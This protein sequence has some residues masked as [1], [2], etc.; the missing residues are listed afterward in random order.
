MPRVFVLDQKENPLMPTPP[1][2]A[3]QLLKQGRAGVPRG[4]YAGTHEGTVLVRKSGYFDIRK[5]GVRI[6]QGINAKYFTLIQ[7]FDGY[8]YK[9]EN[10]R[11]SL[12]QTKRKHAIRK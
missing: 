7:R 4:K 10:L 1:A 2:R 11:P 3:R 8:A 12:R 5:D 9:L 6:A